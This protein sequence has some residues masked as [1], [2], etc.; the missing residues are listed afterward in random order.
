MG[1]TV[2]HRTVF[3]FYNLL[4]SPLFSVWRWLAKNIF[5]ECI[6]TEFFT[7]F[8]ENTFK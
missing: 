4:R 5:Q 2:L 7:I 1:K 8:A 6:F 3:L